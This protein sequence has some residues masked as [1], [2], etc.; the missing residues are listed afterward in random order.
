MDYPFIT[1]S[2]NH[3]RPN[4]K[5]YCRE[6]Q[7]YYKL[8]KVK[9]SRSNWSYLSNSYK[10]THMYIYLCIV[11]P[12]VRNGVLHENWRG[13][14]S[15]PDIDQPSN[16]HNHRRLRYELEHWYFA[17]LSRLA[18]AAAVTSYGFIS[19][20]AEREQGRRRIGG[21]RRRRSVFKPL[22][23]GAGAVNDREPAPTFLSAGRRQKVGGGGPRGRLRQSLFI[24]S[25]AWQS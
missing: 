5:E 9:L 4:I 25:S 22:P 1:W 14:T 13:C 24:S 11:Y 2:Y 23:S 10:H 15:S 20:Q 19:A 21:C 12:A 7:M 6:K 3:Y 18:A 16:D 8:M 17:N